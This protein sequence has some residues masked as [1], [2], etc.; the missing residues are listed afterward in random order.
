MAS[1]C[2]ENLPHDRSSIRLLR[3]LPS[4]NP[5]SQIFCDVFHHD[6]SNEFRTPYEALSY[7]WGDTTQ[8]VDIRLNGCVFPITMNLENALRALRYTDNPRVLWVDA[9]CIDQSN[10]NEQGEQ[11]G[12]MWDI[13]RTA[14]QVVVWLGS[15]DSDSSVAMENLARREASTK[16]KNRTY[17][18]KN[19]RAFQ[20]PDR[21]G[22]P[23]GDF[24]TRP[25]RIGIQNLLGRPWF[26]RIW[27]TLAKV[28]ENEALDSC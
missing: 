1:F 4:C 22:C 20:T 14:E 13:Y 9:V 24:T 5:E 16:N 11:V 15:G 27:V 6:I 26:T 7:T 25:S 12:M 23:A 10:T 21:C 19:N 18:A 28:P 8:T 17:R 3:V 2:Y